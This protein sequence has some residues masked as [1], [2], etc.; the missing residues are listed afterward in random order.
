[1]W[2]QLVQTHRTC[3]YGDVL[4]TPT[5]PLHSDE[6]LPPRLAGSVP[7]YYDGPETDVEHTVAF[8]FGPHGLESR[9]IRRRR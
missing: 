2:S 4:V 7:Y 3:L 1:M 6:D 5:L 8:G 9:V